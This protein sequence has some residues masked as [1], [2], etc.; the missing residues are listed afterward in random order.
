MQVK[1]LSR[2]QRFYRRLLRLLPFDFRWEYGEEMEEVFQE[3]HRETKQERGIMGLARLWGKTLV[4]IFRTAPREH[5][6]MLRQDAGYTLRTMRKNLGFTAIVVFTLALGI[7]ANTAI[8]SMVN[9]VLLRPLPYEGGDRLVVL[10]QQAPLAKVDN[11]RFS[12]KEIVDYREQGNTLDQVVEFHSMEF[13]LMDEGEAQ[14][15]RTGV[16]SANFFDVLGVKPVLGRTFLPGEDAL[17]SEPIL[18]LTYEYWQGRHGGGPEIVGQAFE[19]NGQM[20]TVVGVLP[21]VP[22]YPV[23]RDVYMPT[24]HCPWRSSQRTIDN[25]RSRGMEVFGR[26]KPG[27]TLEQAQAD[28]SV[29]AAR[30]QGD[31]P[32]AYPENAGYAVVSSPLQVKLTE[33]A[34]PT[35]IV[36]LVAVGFVLLIACANVANLTLARVLRRERE[37]ALRAA[38]GAGRGRLL[39]QLVT[40]STILALAGGILG[41]GLAAVTLDS[42]VAFASQFT[43]R[44]FEVTLDGS[45]LLFTLALSVVTG[46][47]FGAIPALTSRK[48]PA[49]SLNEAGSRATPGAGRNRVRTLL[50]ASQV[51]VS[52]MLLIGAGLMLRSFLK[53]QQVEAGFQAENVLTMRVGR[54]FTAFRGDGTRTRAEQIANRL[55]YYRLLQQE[56][57][58]LPG[59][60]SVALATNFPLNRSQGVRRPITIEGHPLP[61]GT[62]IPVTDGNAAGKEYFRTVG[63][64]LLRGRL[65]EESDDMEATAVA[66]ITKSMARR[67]WED[68][69]AIGKRFSQDNGASWITVIGVV[70]NVKQFGLEQEVTDVYYRPYRQT[71]FADRL[72]VRTKV[73]P[74]ILSQ[75]IS[76][77]VREVAP[78]Q[79]LDSVITLEQVRSDSIAR[80]R[81]TAQ[82]IGLFAGLALLITVAGISGVIAVSVSQRTNEFGVRMALGAS[83]ARLLRMVLWQGLTP[84]LIGL[85]LGV[86][87]ALS[88]TQFVRSFLFNIEPADP[89]TF[90]AV[91][92]GLIAAAVAASLIPARRATRID[93]MVALRYE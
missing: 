55:E 43:P 75:S 41:I 36:L 88:L 83:P 45:V 53:L 25:R 79:T 17:G 78:D 50:I 51:A 20:H 59:V 57:K 28:L 10:Q 73:D 11:M 82:L 69:D 86:L 84:V 62:I 32:D 74:M 24:S 70:G 68:E 40:E 61:E 87:G 76:R 27:V 47:V 8:F 4:G 7:G 54:N 1:K 35:L 42:L 31:Y 46:I 9:G 81:L 85:F 91:S 30:L 48:D 19:M 44:A 13:T 14:Q 26:L 5:F 21:P 16:V 72:L 67:Y 71:G 66:I 23:E 33:Q 90:A 56:V 77:I 39:R 92:L 29:I 64:P 2:A 38:L 12:V 89:V 49:A 60:I 58:A 22:Q 65:F 63:I 80:P 37:L 52:F 3:Q 34:R 93:P 6:D 15:V 18:V